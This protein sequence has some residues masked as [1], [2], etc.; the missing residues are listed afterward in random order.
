MKKKRKI[1]LLI[2]IIGISVSAGYGVLR[3]VT[4]EK[5]GKNLLKNGNF[6]RVDRAGKLKVW[7]EDSKGGWS[8]S[9]EEAYQEKRCMQ[10]TVGWSWLSQDVSVKPERYYLLKAYIR[11]DMPL[12]EEGKYENAFLALECLSKKG[13]VLK[14]DYGI[15]GAS[16]SWREEMRQIYAPPGTSRLRV[17]LAKRQGEGSIWFDDVS[18]EQ[19]STGSLLNADFEILDEKGKAKYWSEDSK[20][21]WSVS[22]EGAYQGEKC[23][24]AT[25]GWSWL[26]QDVSVKPEKDYILKVYAKSDIIIPRGKEDWNTFLALECLNEK[27]KVIKKNMIQLNI[28]PLWKAQIISIYAPKD[29]EKLR[30]KLAKRQGEGS[31]WFDDVRIVKSVWYM[32]MKFLRRMAED[33]PFFIFYFSLYFI[34]LILLLRV[35]LKKESSWR[36]KLE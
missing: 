29:T 5:F 23:M 33:K 32:K 2:V 4:G 10:A 9:T 24:Q 14:S 19:V 22:T 30:V 13:E 8:V 6:E 21:G 34:L 15:V 7:R 35:I 28:T 31:V 20:G 16:S 26:S 12:P 1:I 18:L 27:G 11:S 36:D 25:V 3:V 17:K